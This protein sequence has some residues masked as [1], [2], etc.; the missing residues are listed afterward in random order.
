[1]L[2]VKISWLDFY[3]VKPF[4]VFRMSKYSTILQTEA[5][6][7]DTLLGRIQRFWKEVVLYFGHHVCPKKKI[8][9]F[10]WHKKGKS[11]VRSYRFL[12][13][14]FLQYFQIFSIF[15][16]NESLLMKSYQFFKIYRRFNKKREKTL[17]Q[18]SARKEKMEK[19]GI[20]FITCYFIRPFKMAING[21]VM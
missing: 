2:L 11:N 19:V 10:R 13:K 9:G 3:I 20:C 16:Y 14:H 7:C 12:A 8:L 1:M 5:L 17:I 4:C 15:I 18:Q 21:T 6:I